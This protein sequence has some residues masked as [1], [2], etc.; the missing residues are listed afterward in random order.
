MKA[1]STLFCLFFSVAALAQTGII[2]GQL[3]DTT[4]KQNLQGATISVLDKDST[5]ISFGISKADGSFQVNNVPV[6]VN[7]LLISFQGYR[8]EYKN[9][10]VSKD[11]PI[12]DIGT[13][14]LTD[15]AKDL[16]NV[17]IVS[18]PVAIKGDTTEFS[19]NAFK[20]K[21]NASTEDLLKKLPGVQVDK[22]GNVKAQGED[23]KRVLVDGKRFFGDDPKMATRNLPSDVVDK[24]QVYDAQSDQSAFSGF[25][26]GNREKTIN[27]ITKKDRRKG[28][29]GKASAGAGDN[30]RYAANLSVNRFNG[31]QQLSF[32]GQANNTNQQNFSMQDLLG[33]MGGSGMFGGGGGGGMMSA[34][35]GRGMSN[36]GN[37]MGA[38]QAG[39]ARTIAGGL[40]YN[41]AWSK[42]TS[43]SGS[44]FYNNM[45]VINGSDRLRETFVQNDSSLFSR[46]NN[47]STNKNQNHRF[48]FE[49]DHKID[50][51]NSI[52]IRPSFSYQQNDSYSESNSYTTRGKILNVNDLNSQSVSNGNGYNFNNN[53]L[54]RH[55]FRKKGRT[56]SVNLTQAFNESET[57]RRNL[58]YRNNYFGGFIFRD[59]T[60]LLSD[61][62]RSGRT[63]G[64]NISYTEPIDKKSQVEL[65]Y[66]YSN[67]RNESTQET[68]R[69]DGGSS[70]YVQD[71]VLT[72]DFLN[73]N[74]SHRV[75]L[76]YRRQ[77]SKEWSYTVGLGVQHA[78]LESDNRTKNVS[79]SQSFNNLFPTLS[80]QYSKNR[81][82]TLRFNY[83]GST[84]QPNIS[85]LQDVIDITNPL[86]IR[87]G[88]PALNQEFNN[89]LSLMYTSFDIFTFKNFFI[90][91]NGGFVSN[92]IANYLTTN[93]KSQS[94]QYAED[95]ILL[96]PGAQ[97][98]KPV[99][100][101]GA[102]NFSTFV[103]YGFQIKKIKA[104]VNFTTTALFNRDV[105]LVRDVTEAEA[106]R[107]YTKNYVLGERVSFNMNLKDRFDLNFTS[108]TSYTIAKYSRQQELN[109]N[110]FSQMF[111]LE[112]TYTTKTG[113]IFGI[114][115]DYNM[116]RGQGEEF[117]QSVPLFNASV[118]KQVF[119]NKA[120]EIKLYVF[121]L[122]KQNQSI[123]RNVQENFIEDVNTQVLQRYVMLSFTYNLRKFGQ[124]AMPGFMN[125]FRGT[126]MPGTQIRIN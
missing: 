13:I 111:S 32:V 51:F 85:Q 52:L 63:L 74:I 37:F 101:N 118:S 123:T 30:E 90:G 46:S 15:A 110:F 28:Y 43:V 117:N 126:P 19:A 94:V 76:N 25:D 70:K 9:V 17:T 103:N 5:L 113:W 78:I 95:S 35:G 122:F 44:Y 72:N 34:M 23:V 2:K 91:A 104:N 100:V 121:D 38:T 65:S 88:N 108:S 41:D 93:F 61:I 22:D 107:S 82:K 64:G 58:N 84:R 69:Y 16:G 87:R 60:D 86:N 102:Y 31:N 39:I 57:D 77:V 47:N 105:T 48:N 124:K 59:T 4:S 56:L 80:L 68:N 83:R 125:I 54:F 89:N 119:K 79:L 50:S 36:I 26:D 81:A 66:N 8:S 109:N 27:I 116:Y 49:I 114:D 20:T 33:A 11:N 55:R 75:N 10:V 14:I 40:N 67:N 24:V 115:F 112:P 98:S 96:T 42:N 73:N 29:F 106:V 12:T 45:N 71:S 6:G 21:P 3:K 18:A 92:K 97:Y 120:G 53:I 1:I 7:L 99:N 62:E